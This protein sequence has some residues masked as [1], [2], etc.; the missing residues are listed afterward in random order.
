MDDYDVSVLKKAEELG[1][2]IYFQII[3]E[4][5][6]QKFSDILKKY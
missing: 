4:D 5:N 2:E 3:P 6:P 1:T